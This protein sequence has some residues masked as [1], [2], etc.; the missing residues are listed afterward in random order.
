[1]N[2]QLNLHLNKEQLEHIIHGLE[3]AAM[4]GGRGANSTHVE[5][6]P[7]LRLVIH[8]GDRSD[9]DF[10]FLAHARERIRISNLLVETDSRPEGYRA[11]TT[12]RCL[13]DRVTMMQPDDDILEGAN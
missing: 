12:M 8:L 2:A 10:S 7:G 13:G 9:A 4:E 1:M 3:V 5:L 11:V 6:A